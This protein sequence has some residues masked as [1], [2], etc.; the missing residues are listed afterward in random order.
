MTKYNTWFRKR[1]NTVIMI[2]VRS[3][4]LLGAVREEHSNGPQPKTLE[5]VRALRPYTRTSRSY[6]CATTSAG[7]NCRDVR[8]RWN[9]WGRNSRDLVSLYYCVDPTVWQPRTGSKRDIRRYCD[10]S[11]ITARQMNPLCVLISARADETRPCLCGR[12]D[13]CYA[14]KCLAR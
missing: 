12:T 2:Q 7:H 11:V 4:D 3:E 1:T 5:V 13:D 14:A 8:D 10:R 9:G 6:V